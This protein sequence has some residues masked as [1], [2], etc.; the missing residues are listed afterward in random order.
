MK[1]VNRI[2]LKLEN[3]EKCHL[4]CDQDTP[5]GALYDYSCA[6]QSFILGKIQAH[7]DAQ[8]AQ[9]AQEKQPDIQ[10]AE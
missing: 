2:D 1:V 3:F 6:L 7:Q 10:P 5:L 9:K 8:E 4:E